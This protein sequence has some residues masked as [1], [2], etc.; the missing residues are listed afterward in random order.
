MS[1]N[2]KNSHVRANICFHKCDFGIYLLQFRRVTPG[3]QQG[4]AFPRRPPIYF[5]SWVNNTRVSTAIKWRAKSRAPLERDSPA[6]I[7]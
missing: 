6:C 3:D 2:P 4:L 5:V 7:L 1:S